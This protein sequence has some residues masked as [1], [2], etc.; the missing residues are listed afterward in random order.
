MRIKDGRAVPAFVS[1]ALLNE[2][3]TVFGDGS[4]TRSFCYVDDLVA[5]ILKLTDSNVNDPVNIGNPQEMTIAD[6]ARTII[7][8][9]GSK[10]KIIFQD[11]P[12][13]DPKVRQPDITKARTLLGWEPKVP[14]EQG[15]VKT[16]EYF[17][18]K[19]GIH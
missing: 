10:S 8:M 6:M 13:D 15:L 14:L 7:D 1:Q 12:V 9:T 4:Q 2:D 5:G 18:K 3:V 19:M 16:I 17:R 11:L